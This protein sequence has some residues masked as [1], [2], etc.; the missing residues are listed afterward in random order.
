MMRGLRIL[1]RF[2]HDVRTEGGGPQ[3]EAAAIAVGT[4]IGCLPLY[5]LH[6]LLC[7]AV[8]TVF[9]LNRLK[10]YLAANVSNPLVAPWLLLTE[11]QAGAFIRRGSFHDLT[12]Q[13][14]ETT[15]LSVFAG[16]LAAGSVAVGALLAALAGWGTYAVVRRDR[17]DDRFWD[18]VRRATE[19]YASTSLTAWEFARGKLRFDPIY[20][21]L[22]CD[23]LLIGGERPPR[24]GTLVEIGCGQGL[25]LALLS[26]A[27]AD[28]RSDRWPA[29]W[30]P[31]VFDRLVGIEKRRRVARI[32]SAA[33][34]GEAEIIAADARSMAIDDTDVVLFVDVLHMM[35]RDQQEAVL[36]SACASLSPE[37]RVIVREANAAG[38]WRF[39]LV[40][41]SNRLKAVAFG[42]WRQRFAFRSVAEW[43]ACFSRLGLRCET[44]AMG[45][46]TPFANVLF[47]VTRAAA[48]TPSSDRTDTRTAGVV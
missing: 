3:R 9:R 48:A 27:R 21:S 1:R 12:M 16:D 6:L 25:I 15:G 4:F 18:L 33:L 41:T 31:V 40:S 28:V 30:P 10:M 7:I 11:V 39:R 17:A 13:T 29:A 32:A 26:E 43:E 38:G 23:G 34:A 2:I 35:S 8:G 5:G 45:Q 36:A 46:G 42:N 44:R 20:R 14:L 19:R 22:V 37:G 47:V 24:A